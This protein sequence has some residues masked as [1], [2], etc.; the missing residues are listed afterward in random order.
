MSTTRDAYIERLKVQLD[1]WNAELGRMEEQAEAVQ[2]GL[3]EEYLRQ[4][5]E[6]RKERDTYE[7]KLKE[8]MAA[9][10]DAWEDLR[11]AMEQ[12]WEDLRRGM[13]QAHSRFKD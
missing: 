10:E 13:I 6:L 5:D 12:S 7:G 1:E 8:I 3:K 11:K 9:G 4:M 2:A